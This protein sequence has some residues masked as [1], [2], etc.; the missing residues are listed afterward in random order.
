MF[1]YR[2]LFGKIE[3]VEIK[4]ET[5]TIVVLLSGHREHK[6]SEDINWFDFWEDAHKFLISDTAR[7]LYVAQAKVRKVE[8]EL[9]EIKDM[10]NPEGE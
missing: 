9:E 8:R 5:P 4:R 2:T 1:K 10:K 6:Q 7:K 3:K